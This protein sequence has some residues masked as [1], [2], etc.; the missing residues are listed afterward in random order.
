MIAP[1]VDDA[2]EEDD[3]RTWKS[4]CLIADRHAIVYFSQL[5]MSVGVLGFCFFQLVSSDFSCEK[6]GPYW[7]TVTLIIGGIM[8]RISTRK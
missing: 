7:A 5:F 4:C 2:K 3:G 8:G 1:E 6:S